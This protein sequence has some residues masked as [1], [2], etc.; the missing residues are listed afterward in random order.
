[1]IMRDP[2]LYR[3]RHA[4]HYRT[5]DEWCI[6]PLY[7]YAHCL[8]DAFEGI[9]HSICTLE[10]EINRELYDWVLDEAG[11]EEPRTHQYEFAR[12]NLEYT[13]LS[14]RRL[15]RLVEEGHVTGWDDPRMSTVAAYRRRGVPP[16]ALRSFCEMI[17]VTKTETRVDLEKLEYAIRN[18]LNTTA[19]RVMGVLRPLPLIVTSWP[20]GSEEWLEAPSFPPD[21]DR[22]GSRRVPFARELLIER[23][24]FA[25]DPPSGW[26]RLAPGREVRLR[27]GYVVRYEGH[28]L[29]PATS[30]VTAVRV[31]HDPASRGG[32]ARGRAVSGTI[33]WVSARHAV[34]AEMRLYDRLFTVPDPEDPARGDRL[35]REPESPI[36]RRTPRRARGAEHRRGAARQLL[37]AR[38]HGLL[39]AGP[40][41][42]LARP[43]GAEPRGSRCGT[44]GR[45]RMRRWRIP[46]RRARASAEGRRA[47]C[48]PDGPR[49]TTSRPFHRV[50]IAAGARAT[51]SG[52]RLPTWR[53]AWPAIAP[54]S[55]WERK[56]RTSSPPIR[57]WPISSTV[58]WPCTGAPGAWPRG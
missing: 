53:R 15:I 6:Y 41:R 2:V 44:A 57:P 49:R 13:I 58:P 1:M 25:I 45:A 7:D 23:E 24:D 33:H 16:A 9:S 19:P 28:D 39:L 50:R 10:F 38:A 21:V 42:P 43:P 56:R 11:V 36:A 31:T 54:R 51:R 55:A 3:I 34:P 32:D 18:E 37:A 35:H 5:G 40:G 48:R 46:R 14:K 20:E 4:H 30:E 26:R 8:E 47:P 27:Y 52:Q 29:D 12:L 17:G 22:E